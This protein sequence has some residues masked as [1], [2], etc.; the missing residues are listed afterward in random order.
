MIVAQVQHRL[1]IRSSPQPIGTTPYSEE[2]R[3]HQP[4]LQLKIDEHI[5]VFSILVPMTPHC[6]G[7]D[8]QNLVHRTRKP[9]LKQELS[10]TSR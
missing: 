5:L 2:T 6:G 7:V 8:R 10:E 4:Y 1:G 3:N 9:T